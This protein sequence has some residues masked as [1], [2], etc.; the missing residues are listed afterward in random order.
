VL[1]TLVEL[2]KNCITPFSVLT[3]CSS[4][5]V[6][7]F[8]RLFTP[9]SHL[10]PFSNPTSPTYIKESRGLRLGIDTIRRSNLLHN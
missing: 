8:Y 10:G 5:F 6:E 1:A 2:E 7:N 4:V 3:T 9:S